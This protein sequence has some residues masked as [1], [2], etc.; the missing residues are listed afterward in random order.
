M[1]KSEVYSWRLDPKTKARLEA[2]AR[3]DGRSLAELL[4]E[5]TGEWLER[6]GRAPDEAEQAR[7]R[8]AAAAVIGTLTSGP[9]DR[10][11][12][13][14]ERVRARLRARHGRP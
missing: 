2:A 12:R 6:T 10:S 7:R 1:S 5:I 9:S 4:D 11:T 8:R 14:R 13:V 3:K